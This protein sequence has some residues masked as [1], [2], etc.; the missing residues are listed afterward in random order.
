MQNR[1]LAWTRDHGDPIAVEVTV[2]AQ[3]ADRAVRILDALL[4]ALAVAGVETKSA[5][6]GTRKWIVHEVQGVQFRLRVREVTRREK[7]ISTPEELAQARVS[8][9]TT[10]PMWD[11]RPT[12]LFSLTMC[13]NR[14]ASV[15]QTWTEA[16][17]SRF[18]HR[19]ADLA[20]G[21]LS[22]VDRDLSSRNADFNER[23]RKVLEMEERRKADAAKRAEDVQVEDLF[24]EAKRWED[25]RRVRRY[26]RVARKTMLEI[27]GQIV[28]GSQMDRWFVWANEMARQMDPLTKAQ[29]PAATTTPSATS[30]AVPL[31]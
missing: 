12:G 7:C 6:D 28:P 22:V 31:A 5:T 2:S 23:R 19:I 3:Q 16:K 1:H 20:H 30:S 9:S 14:W 18:E 27:H 11:Y 29:R 24:Q 10:I 26:L 8:S 17:K 4:R 25:S 13:D 21:I 15:R